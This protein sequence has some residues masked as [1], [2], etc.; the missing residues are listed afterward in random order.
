NLILKE[1]TDKDT[2]PNQFFYDTLFSFGKGHILK[3]FKGSYFLNIPYHE[4]W[5]VKRLNL[6]NGIITIGE[7]TSQDDI[8]TMETITETKRDTTSPFKVNPTK[9]QLKR[10]IKEKGFT[11]EEFYIKIN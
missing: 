4:N 6:K 7:I 5:E 9:R 10:F 8:T 3:K 11:D 1:Y 2:I